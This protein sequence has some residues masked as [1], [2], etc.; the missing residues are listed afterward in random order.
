MRVNLNKQ[1]NFVCK[2]GF[3]NQFSST[4]AI[5]CSDERFV[6]CSMEFLQKQLKT[7]RCDLIVY[8]GGPQFIADKGKAAINRV[9]FLIEAHNISHVILISHIDCGY[10]KH[11]YPQLSAEQLSEKQISDI[12]KSKQILSSIFPSVHVESFY[13]K[14][15]NQKLVFEPIT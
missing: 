3:K 15:H 1:K 7:K 10:Y 13:I 8:P 12:T 2:K 11:T 6:G 4:L 9:K 14:L 5:F